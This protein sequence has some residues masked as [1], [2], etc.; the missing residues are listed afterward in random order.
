MIRG[1]TRSSERMK[2]SE[3]TWKLSRLSQSLASGNNELE[4]NSS[5]VNK[6]VSDACVFYVDGPC[7]RRERRM[8]SFGFQEAA[9][10]PNMGRRPFRPNLEAAMQNLTLSLF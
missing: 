6:S 4:E 9:A 2:V 8:F 10:N 1:S 7:W 3:R 5:S